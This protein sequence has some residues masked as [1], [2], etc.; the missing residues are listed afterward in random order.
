MTLSKNC[1]SSQGDSGGPLIRVPESG[2][3]TLFGILSTTTAD[4][5]RSSSFPGVWSSISNSTDV[6]RHL[7]WICDITGV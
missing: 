2:K 6:R 3:A 1:S 4:C 5:Y 7:N